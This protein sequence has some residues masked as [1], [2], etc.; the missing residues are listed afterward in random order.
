M[1]DGTEIGK[2]RGLGSGHQG[3]EHWVHQRYTAL[4]NL[5]LGAWFVVS[6]LLLSSLDL[7]S[8][9][10]WLVK[11]I[12]ATALI[13]LIVSTFYHARLGLQ[14]A[15]EDYVPDEGTKAGLIGLLSLVFI[16]VG[17]FAVFCVLKIALTT[18][19]SVL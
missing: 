14:V 8:I 7:D 15:I 3:S 2:V 4:G 16:A 10:D 17:T 12:P 13:L 18:G 6:L 1:G 5:F 9:R 11:P 19:G